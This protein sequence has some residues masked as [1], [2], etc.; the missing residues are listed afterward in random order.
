MGRLTAAR[1]VSFELTSSGGD[2]LFDQ[3]NEASRVDVA[4]G[5]GGNV[6]FGILVP[7][8][9]TAAIEGCAGEVIF[10]LVSGEVVEDRF[11]VRPRA[12]YSTLAFPGE[13]FYLFA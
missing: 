8:K 5:L 7:I 6:L 3:G 12:A 4:R 9:T 10:A 11:G 2:P 13:I 1:L